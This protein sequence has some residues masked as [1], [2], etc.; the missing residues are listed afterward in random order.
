VWESWSDDP[1]GKW[2]K[3]DDMCTRFDTI[4]QRD[5]QTDRQTEGNRSIALRM[6][7]SDNYKRKERSVR[8]LSSETL[9]M[10][11]RRPRLS[12]SSRNWRNSSRRQ[13]LSRCASCRLSVGGT[14]KTSGRLPRLPAVVARHAA[15]SSPGLLVVRGGQTGSRA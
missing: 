8:T 10:I 13:W 4:P 15:A 2:T 1:T 6:L 3:C 12:S 9:R 7:T 14:S 5:R 11:A